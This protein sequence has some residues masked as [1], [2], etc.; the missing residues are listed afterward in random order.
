MHLAQADAFR[1]TTQKETTAAN[2]RERQSS[3]SENKSSPFPLTEDAR[4]RLARRC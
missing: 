2:R 3:L 1:A 4:L